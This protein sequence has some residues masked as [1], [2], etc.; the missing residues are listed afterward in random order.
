MNLK[1]RARRVLTEAGTI[2]VSFI[3]AFPVILGLMGIAVDSSVHSYF[4]QH[5][6]NILD[7]AV[8]GGAQYVY[9]SGKIDANCAY[10]AALYQYSQNR[11][12]VA[13]RTPVVSKVNTGEALST[14]ANKIGITPRMCSLSNFASYKNLV[15]SSSPGEVFVVTKFDVQQPT[16][17]ATGVHPG[18][19]TMCVRENHKTFFLS[20]LGKKYQTLDATICSSASNIMAK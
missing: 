18:T 13:A 4:Q 11:S 5:E 9:K 6:T 2:T 1:E 14:Q 20:F 7:T 12:Q 17:D 19:I 10:G 3:I 8:K 16:V 15:M